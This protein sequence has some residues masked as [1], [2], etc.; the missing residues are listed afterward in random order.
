MHD[1]LVWLV[2]EVAVPAG[3][4][5]FAWPAVH[6]LQLFLGRSNLDTSFDTVGCEWACAVD[7]PLLEDL[8]L[9]L[10][11]ASHEV[12]ERFDMRLCAVR[13]ECEARVS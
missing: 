3:A 10:G 6:H 9:Y 5:L 12:V 8:L 7:V 11:V 4:E 13:G 2:L 1:W